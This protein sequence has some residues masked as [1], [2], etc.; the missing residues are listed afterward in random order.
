MNKRGLSSIITMLVTFLLVIVAITIIWNFLSIL[1][2]R[3]TEIIKAKSQLF[4]ENMDFI[5]IQFNQSDPLILTINIQKRTSGAIPIEVE[6]IETPPPEVDIVSVVDLSGSMRWCLNVNQICCEDLLGG[7]YLPLLG[8]CPD[9]TVDKESL[10]VSSPQC[11]G[12]WDDK[13]TPAQNA[14]KELIDRLL[15]LGNNNRIGLVGYNGAVVS[16]A[17]INLTDNIGD[18]NAKIDTWHAK[19]DTCI[20]CGINEAKKQLE[21]LSSE[22]KLKTMIVMSDGISWVE[23]AEQNTGD[24]LQDAIKAACDANNTLSNLTI[25]SIG[26]GGGVDESTLESIAECGGGE[27]FSA[28]NLDDLTVAYQTVVQEVIQKS[29]DSVQISNYLVIVFYSGTDSYREII[30]D[31]PENLQTKKYSFDLNGKLG[32]EITKIEIYPVIVT[33]KGEEIV[34][35][36]LDHWEK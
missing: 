25:H 16:L 9:V 26:F 8:Q 30:T 12:I 20:C 18:L 4:Y 27:F 6:I 34:G 24:S 3:E 36:L 33:S 5:K 1:I 7:E 23:C 11:E 10:C 28:D 22:E 15:N 2:E 13:L 19:D 31:L 35:P 21:Q 29:Q 14:N 17:S 32:G